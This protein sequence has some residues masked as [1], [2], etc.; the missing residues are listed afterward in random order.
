MSNKKKINV[1][2]I[3]SD[4][5]GVGYFRS[6]KPHIQLEAN[7]PDE[8]KIDIDYDVD[9]DN[10]NI[11]K[12]YDIVHYHRNL[13]DYDKT[14]ARVQKLKDLGI[15]GIMDLDDYWLPNQ[16]HPS[17]HAIKYHGFDKKIL[18]NVKTAQY[19]TTTTPLF[20]DEIKKVNKNVF[21]IPNAVDPTEKQYIPKPEK[22]DRLRIGW[23][24]GSS[25]LEDLRLLDGVANKLKSSGLIDKI[26]LVLC[27]FDTRGD[28]QYQDPN[29][30]ELKSRPQYPE[31]TVWFKYEQIFT[32]NYNIVSPKYKKFLYE[33]SKDEYSDL[34][35]EP[36]RRVWTK[37]I[38][39]YA[40]NYNLFDV[41][42]APL[43]ENTFNKV[44]SQLKVIEAG[45]HKKA[46]IA[47]NFGPY[48]LDLKNIFDK[49]SSDSGITLNKEGNGIL[50]DK[51]K[52]HKDWFKNIK[53]LVDNPEI[54]K[55]LQIRLYE[56]VKDKY[57]L[58]E[59]SKLR[60]DLYLDLINKK[61][62]A[63]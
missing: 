61:N 17:Y 15:I 56:T 23:L 24:G 21:V 30:G 31:E 29:T 20:S 63:K 13:M 41:S 52:N 36:Y 44:K 38:T 50:I 18:N 7:Y 4:R 45:F 58:G 25:H 60:R 54:V 9:L 51:V 35:N 26:Q 48:T 40:S 62:V 39:T 43:T 10:E 42:L 8:F 3:P 34:D 55:E 47:Q 12:K 16:Q 57:N 37:P 14:E 53:R 2:V 6:T 22:S 32:D 11:L 46:I 49:G 1:L 59:V 33:F 5:A 28:I 19:I 27:G